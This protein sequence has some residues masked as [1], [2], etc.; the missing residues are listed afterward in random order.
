MCVCVCVCVRACV[1][2]CVCARAC[3]CVCA[4]ACVC[5]CACA[6]VCARARVC[7]C[8]FNDLLEMSLQ[9]VPGVGGFRNTSVECDIDGVE[10]RPHFIGASPKRRFNVM[11]QSFARGALLLY[12]NE[13]MA[14][15][16]CIEIRSRNFY[17]KK[18]Q[19][20]AN[21]KKQ[22]MFKTTTKLGSTTRVGF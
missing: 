3:V 2:V 15:V 19:Q 7:V 11:T 14:I 10:L 13:E 22:I 16:I 8:D 21:K 4:R 9:F 18:K 20:K 17:S 1:R 12:D 5:V 6:C